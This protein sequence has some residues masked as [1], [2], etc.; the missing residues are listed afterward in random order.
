MNPKDVAPAT[1]A[2]A[3]GALKAKR[4]ELTAVTKALADRIH[5]AERSIAALRVGVTGSVE[6]E[7]RDEDPLWY[8]ELRFEKYEKEW[9][10]MV[11][12]GREDRPDYWDEYMPLANAP[13]SIRME[14]LDHLTELVINMINN[15]DGEI[16]AVNESIGTVEKFVTDLDMQA[17]ALA[18]VSNPQSGAADPGNAPVASKKLR[19]K[20]PT[21]KSKAP[22]GVKPLFPTTPP[23]PGDK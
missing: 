8:R 3:L 5:E 14:A 12:T 22:A 21:T 9:R 16:R 2:A 20:V 10:L 6:I 7:R 15:V 13:R 23:K 4:E 1:L 18:Q 19:F 17:A 11:A